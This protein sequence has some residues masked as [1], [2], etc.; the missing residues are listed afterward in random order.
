MDN[1]ELFKLYDS[2]LMLRLHNAKNLSDTRKMLAR[3][4]EYLNGYPPSPELAK[5]F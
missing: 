2:D 4:K 3:F 1:D 5:S